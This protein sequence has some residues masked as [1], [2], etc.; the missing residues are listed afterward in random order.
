VYALNLLVE[1]G[2]LV[3]GLRASRKQVVGLQW[4]LEK[5]LKYRFCDQVVEFARLSLTRSIVIDLDRPA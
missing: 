4:A 5:R 3:F 1:L 2:V